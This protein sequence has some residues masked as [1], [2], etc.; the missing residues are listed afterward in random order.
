MQDNQ[1]CHSWLHTVLPMRSWCGVRDAMSPSPP[2]SSDAEQPAAAGWGS[3]ES[4]PRQTDLCC[5]G[6]ASCL[7][8]CLL[9]FTE[10]SR[11]APAQQPGSRRLPGNLLDL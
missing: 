3:D 4:V 7:E 2:L 1:G 11:L 5:A 10:V 8:K 6:V 9:S